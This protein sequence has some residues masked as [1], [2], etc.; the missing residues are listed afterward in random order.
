MCVV[1]SKKIGHIL[2]TGANICDWA[3]YI[4]FCVYI[5]LKICQIFVCIL[6]R[7]KF[8]HPRARVELEFILEF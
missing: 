8:G 6:I 4:D 5:I 3:L 2:Y 1:Y 7:Y